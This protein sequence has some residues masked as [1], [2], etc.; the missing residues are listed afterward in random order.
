MKKSNY[1]G[2]FITTII[3]ILVALVLLKVWFDFNIIDFLKSPKVSEWTAYLRE[4]ITFVWQH[5]LKD[6]F[7]AIWN[8]VADLIGRAKA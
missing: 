7:T 6:A 4:V 5:Y 3:I 8:F 2:G 1:R